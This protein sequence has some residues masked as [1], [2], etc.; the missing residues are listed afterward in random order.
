MEIQPTAT[1]AG[2][3]HQF[4]HCL[5]LLAKFKSYYE[6]FGDG[7]ISKGQFEKQWLVLKAL[8]L[9]LEQVHVKGNALIASE[10]YRDFCFQALGLMNSIGLH[11]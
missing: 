1:S 11:R 10:L 2:V 7:T 6:K 3:D 8:Y 5:L 9:E 4:D